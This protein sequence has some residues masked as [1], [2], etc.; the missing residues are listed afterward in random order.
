MHHPSRERCKCERRPWQETSLF[1]RG[2]SRR[3]CR[4]W[5]HRGWRYQLQVNHLTTAILPLDC[6]LREEN[7]RL[8][9]PDYD[10]DK[11][12]TNHIK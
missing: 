5:N 9:T 8:L 2:A 11:L 4:S 1:S 6:H 12:S 7:D 10:N 3:R